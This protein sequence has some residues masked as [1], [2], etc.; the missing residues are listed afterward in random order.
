MQV[1]ESKTVVE[2]PKLTVVECIVGDETGVVVFS[3]KNE[4]GE[5][6]R[7]PRTAVLGVAARAHAH[8]AQPPALVAARGPAAKGARPV[9]SVAGGAR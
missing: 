3:A 8:M 9:V 6:R 5:Q 4:Q 7:R 1:L 2:R